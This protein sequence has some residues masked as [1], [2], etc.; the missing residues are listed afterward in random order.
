MSDASSAG[1]HGKT[2]RQDVLG[3]IDIPVVPGTTGGARPV[4]DRKLELRE[5]MPA[6]RASLA[7]RKPAVNDDELPSV[8]LTL[9]R[10]L[11]AELGPTAVRDGAGQL[12]VTDQAGDVQVLDHDC[13]G[14]ADK[15]GAS[16]MQEVAPRVADL[17]VGAGDL[18]FSLFPVRGTLLAAGQAPLVSSQFAGL[19]VQVQGVGDP[20]AVAG[21]GVNR[22]A[23]INAD[24]VPGLWQWFGAPG[25]DGEGHVPAA[26]RLPADNDHRRVQRSQ[27]HLRPSPGE[28]QRRGRLGQPQHPVAQGERRPGI[29]RGLAPSARFEPGVAS[30]F[31]IKRGERRPAS[32]EYRHEGLGLL[33][34]SW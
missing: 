18:E 3:R 16:P 10:Q 27:V 14:G 22:H 25:I 2:C 15:P 9:V 31:L 23:E 20:V 6:R 17:T 21:H 12:S 1:S 26:V 4:A 32:W 28:P 34:R 11:A 13:V 24:G 30:A 8:P 7:R 5:Y 29:V 19:A 33:R